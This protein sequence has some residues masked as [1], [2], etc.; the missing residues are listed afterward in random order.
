VAREVRDLEDRITART[1]SIS[2][3]FDRIQ[4]ILS[5]WGYLDG[6]SLTEAGERL[7]RI[8]HE[9]DLLIAEALGAGLLDDLDPASLAGLVSVFTYEHRSSEAP[10]APW[11]PSPKV[12]RRWE[13]IAQLATELRA[14]EDE[15]ALPPTRMPDPTFVA[16]AHA[17]AAGESFRDVLEDEELTG[18]DF[19]RNIKQL[20]DLLRQ[21]GDVA[22][23]AST[24]EAAKLAADA[25][26]RGVVA[27]SSRVG[28]T[29]P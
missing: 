20:I 9:C 8:F 23:V 18:G 19:V 29:E 21:V 12:R 22:P 6:W 25:L 24:A 27:A 17:W 1:A 13:A 7:A 5:E 11:F 3:R 10:P 16:V 15:A 4:R 14:A 2:R 26:F 28:G